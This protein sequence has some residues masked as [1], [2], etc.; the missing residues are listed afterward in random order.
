VK[1]IKKSSQFHLILRSQE[2]NL[3]ENS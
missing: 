1:E 3:I 2:N